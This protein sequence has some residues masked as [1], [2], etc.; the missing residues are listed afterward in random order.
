MPK[1]DAYGFRITPKTLPTTP[2]PSYTE[3]TEERLS[4]GKKRFKTVMFIFG[5]IALVVAALLS[6]FIAWN[7][8]ANDL[9]L[10]R[11]CKTLAAFVFGIPYL[12]YFFILRVVLQV[13]CF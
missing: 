4:K 12:C 9:H 8:Y 11:L 10:I 7:C 6:G 2:P 1:Y 3:T 5:G 13:P